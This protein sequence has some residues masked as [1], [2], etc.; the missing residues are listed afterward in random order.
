LVVIGSWVL[1]WISIQ[2]QAE[3]QAKS[4]DGGLLSVDRTKLNKLRQLGNGGWQAQCPACAET[5]S[6]RKGEH[7]RISADGKFG[8][9]VFPGD[10]EH[11]RRI[12]ALVGDR[13][14]KEIRVRVASRTAG[15]VTQGI[16]SRLVASA[17]CKV[18]NGEC[19]QATSD[20]SDGA[21]Q[22]QKEE[23]KIQNENGATVRTGRTGVFLVT[24]DR[25]E[26]DDSVS[27]L[28]EFE[29]P[30]RSVRQELPHL[31]A[32]GDLVIPFNSPKRYHWWAGGQ[33]IRQTRQEIMERKENNASP[34]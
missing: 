4:G 33:S 6:D 3:R 11:R 8:C 5:G 10:R 12:F 24:R 32:S 1:V 18:E 29:E 26:T 23:C 22:M 17:E 28:I 7:L 14:L 30:V 31:T 25:E 27:K 21:S 13:G 34:F 20:G 2:L 15:P 19:G 9:C 16:L